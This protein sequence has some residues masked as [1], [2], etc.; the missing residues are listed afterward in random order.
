MDEL[1][2]NDSLKQNTPTISVIMPV[3]N[4]ESF[5][6]EAIESILNQTYTNFKLILIDDGSEDT[7]LQIMK[8]YLDSRIIIIKNEKN[9]GLI[10]ALNKGLQVAQGEYIARMD[11]DDVSHPQRFEKQIEF[12]EQNSDI[13]L[14]GTWANLINNMGEIV[15]FVKPSPSPGQIKWDLHFSNAIAH[16]SVMIRKSFFQRNGQYLDSD[17]HCEDYALWVRAFNNTKLSNL[18]VILINLRQH[19]QNVSKIYS[20]IQINQ[21]IKVSQIALS[22]TLKYEIPL[23]IVKIINRHPNNFPTGEYLKTIKILRQFQHSYLENSSL[24]CEEKKYIKKSMCII[25]YTIGILPI[26]RNPILSLYIFILSFINE[27]LFFIK[28]SVHIIPREYY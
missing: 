19:D 11:Q 8:S 6:K 10:T 9:F 4:G 24:S 21:A 14:C 22:S 23:N 7:S 26:R 15:N 16:P 1:S 12:L 18:P 25:L 2:N 28:R 3:Y 20:E 17:I 13:G 5:L 27:P